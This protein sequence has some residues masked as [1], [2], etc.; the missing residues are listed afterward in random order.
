MGK[1]R[2]LSGREVCGIPT[3]HGF[4]EVRRRGSL[5][6]GKSRLLPDAKEDHETS[7]NVGEDVVGDRDGADYRVVAGGGQTRG[8]DRQ[9]HVPRWVSIQLS[10]GACPPSRAE[11]GRRGLRVLDSK[12]TSFQ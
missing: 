8:G 4:L 6:Q 1:L 10:R 7:G 3:R 2:V 12:L 9:Q 5:R 11:R